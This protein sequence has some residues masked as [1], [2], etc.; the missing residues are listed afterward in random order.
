MLLRCGNCEGAFFS[1]LHCNAPFLYGDNAANTL[2]RFKQ[3]FE[4]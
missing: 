4:I 3:I 2:W 1:V